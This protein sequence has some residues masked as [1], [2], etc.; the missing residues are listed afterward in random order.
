M[1]SSGLSLQRR[2]SDRIGDAPLLRI[3]EVH[4]SIACSIDDSGIQHIN[5]QV[6]TGRRRDEFL[7]LPEGEG[8][9]ITF[10][11]GRHPS[12][13]ARFLYFRGPTEWCSIFLGKINRRRTA[14]SRNAISLVLSSITLGSALSVESDYDWHNANRVIERKLPF[15]DRA[16]RRRSILPRRNIRTPFRRVP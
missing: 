9:P 6:E 7:S 13:S 14:L 16:V 1:S 11:P 10:G 5:H 4:H 3:D 2:V 12:S 15:R 8:V